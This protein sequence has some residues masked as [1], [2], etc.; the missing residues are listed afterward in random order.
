MLPEDQ[1]CTCGS[2]IPGMHFQS[3]KMFNAGIFEKEALEHES[4][5]LVFRGIAI[6]LALGL[7]L[8]AIMILILVLIF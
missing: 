8:W 1:P 3:C 7:L 5:L 6:G 2:S 4:S